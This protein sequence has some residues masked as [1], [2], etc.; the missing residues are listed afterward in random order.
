VEVF[1]SETVILAL[2]PRR[3]YDCDGNEHE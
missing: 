2:R 1:L 3:H